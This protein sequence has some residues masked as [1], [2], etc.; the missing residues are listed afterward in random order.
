MGR[1]DDRRMAQVG[2]FG[3]QYVNGD[4]SPNGESGVGATVDLGLS[5]LDGGNIG[6][7]AQVEAFVPSSK[8]ASVDSIR[9]EAVD[10]ALDVLSRIVSEDRDEVK[11]LLSEPPSFDIKKR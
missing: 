5:G 10:R 2:V 6:P 3:M 8:D 4:E 7:L 11:R 9:E 1:F